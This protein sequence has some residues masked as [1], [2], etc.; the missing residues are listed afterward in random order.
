MRAG[1][2][3]IKYNGNICILH[4]SDFDGDSSSLAA[5]QNFENFTCQNDQFW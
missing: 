2:V 4:D 1:G 5:I 3:P